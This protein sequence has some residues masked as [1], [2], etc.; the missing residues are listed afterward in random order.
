MHLN[1]PK[2]PSPPTP[3]LGNLFST[4]PIPGAKKVRDY[5]YRRKEHQ[6]AGKKRLY[7]LV[8]QKFLRV[9]ERFSPGSAQPFTLALCLG[10]FSLLCLVLWQA[11]LSHLRSLLSAPLGQLGPLPSLTESNLCS[12]FLLLF[13]LSPLTIHLFFAP[14]IPCHMCSLLAV[15]KFLY[16]SG[17]ELSRA[18]SFP[19]RG[20]DTAGAGPGESCSHCP[21]FGELPNVQGLLGG[22]APS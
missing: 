17:T 10:S 22:G 1:H 20:W 21:T 18:S 6:K 5:C 7:S 14:D 19:P 2:P 15:T 9:G 12:L 11:I 8:I 4:K 3:V 13:G 16:N